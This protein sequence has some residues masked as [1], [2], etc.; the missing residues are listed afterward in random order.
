MAENI[1]IANE[2]GEKFE[3]RPA[4]FT[5]RWQNGEFR[6]GYLYWQEGMSDW[7]PVEEYFG[8]SG[9]EASNA[10]SK[11]TGDGEQPKGPYLTAYEAEGEG[12]LLIVD[13]RGKAMFAL[14]MLWICM[15][16]EALMLI[17][18]CAQLYIYSLDLSE[19]ETLA[20]DLFYG[21]V[22]LGYLV[23]YLTTAVAFLMWMH[24]MSKNAHGFA[25]QQMRYSPGWTVGYFFIP[26]LNLFRPFQ[27]MK[28]IWNASAERAD[29]GS[30]Q[31]DQILGIWW[32]LWLIGNVLGQVTFRTSL[33]ADTTEELEIATFVSIAS[34]I[35]G[36]FL[37][38][39]AIRMVRRLTAMQQQQRA[40]G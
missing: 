24:S 1:H 31:N 18:D 25:P 16:S 11:D 19:D 9:G 32:T 4:E 39:V 2:S 35:V 3:L 38:I 5:S 33:N 37:C 40:K 28:D 26:I 22:G 36:I 21:L 12:S 17:M 27:A 6:D 10:D 14:V 13:P 23:A 20:F 29:A 34:D 30:T 8:E 15:A 7:K